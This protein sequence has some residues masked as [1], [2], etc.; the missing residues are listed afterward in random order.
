MSDTAVIEKI[1]TTD[2]MLRTVNRGLMIQWINAD[3]MSR[4]GHD[5]DRSRVFYDADKMFAFA[6]LRGETVGLK[7]AEEL[8]THGVRYWSEGVV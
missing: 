2:P 3:L 7:M 4:A 5:I 8:Y 1:T 6:V